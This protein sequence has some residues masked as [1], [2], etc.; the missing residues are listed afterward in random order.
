M[1]KQLP[2]TE[3]AER[4]GLIP[5]DQSAEDVYFQKNGLEENPDSLLFA[6]ST[7]PKDEM[8]YIIRR[9]VSKESKEL[10]FDIFAH[11]YYPERTL[12]ELREYE[13]YIIGKLA[14]MPAISKILG[15]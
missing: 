9:F 12:E 15:K 8:T 7:M 11:F 3:K 2:L 4:K 14:G 5:G 10:D 13:A 1:P 6:L